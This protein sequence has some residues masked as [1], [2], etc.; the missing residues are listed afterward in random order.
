MREDVK[1]YETRALVQASVETG[2]E[3]KAVQDAWK[4][5]SDKFF[6]YLAA[7]RKKAD[8][9]AMDYLKRETAKGPMTVR[10]LAPLMKSNLRRK[11]RNARNKN[12]PEL[13]KRKGRYGRYK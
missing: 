10:P 7:R 11:R 9:A 5:Y 12:M 13:R 8:A 6:P 3:G 4:G 2:D 1:Y